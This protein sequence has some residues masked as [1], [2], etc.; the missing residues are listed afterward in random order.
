M[1]LSLS[2]VGA[3][4]VVCQCCGRVAEK[5]GDDGKDAVRQKR[6]DGWRRFHKGRGSQKE[7]TGQ[8]EKRL[9]RTL[10][11]G[12]AWST[13]RKS[14]RRYRG[15]FD[16]FF[17]TEHRLRKEEMEEQ[18]NKEAKEGWRFAADAARITDE[19]AGREDHKRRIWRSFCGSRQQTGDSYWRE[20]RSSKVNVRGGMRMFA[21]YFWHTEGWSPSN[22]A[23]LEAVLKSA[24]TT[25]HP[26][27]TASDAY[28]SPEDFEK[29]LWFRN[30]QMHVIAPDGVPTCR[31]KNA[32]VVEEGDDFVIACS[33]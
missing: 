9:K 26:W 16:I 25:K 20:R 27:L 19:R 10:L 11:S 7:K 33:S 28:M 31:S 12:S 24:R 21:A 4:L 2:A 6:A 30:D 13:E 5:D 14:M 15:T 22:E 8:E 29:S 3:E 17:G 23:V 1:A 18:F 32:K